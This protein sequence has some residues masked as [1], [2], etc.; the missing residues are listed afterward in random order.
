MRQAAANRAR[1][2][3]EKQIERADEIGSDWCGPD[4][5]FDEE[6]NEKANV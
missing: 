2:W 6:L 4:S 3:K 1:L 5:D